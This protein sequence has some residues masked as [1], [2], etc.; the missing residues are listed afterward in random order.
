MKLVIQRVKEATVTVEDQI[1]GSIKEGLLVLVGIH[2]KDTSMDVDEMSRKLVSL[3][4]FSSPNSRWSLN[5]KDSDNSVLLVSQFTLY[6]N[7]EKGSKP[8]FHDAMAGPQ[9][10]CF[11]NAFVESVGLALG[12]SRVQTGAFGK[13][14]NVSLVNDGPVTILLESKSFKKSSPVRLVQDN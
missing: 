14:M 1:V 8:D 7:T 4:L 5:L 12:K 3:R 6:S 10:E 9:A 11:F 13:Y 2:N